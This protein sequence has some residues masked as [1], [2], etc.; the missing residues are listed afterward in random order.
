MK[1]YMQPQT[2]SLF[3][4]PDLMKVVGDGGGSGGSNIPSQPNTAPA[5]NLNTLYI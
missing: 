1:K 3:V 2:I 4:Y 5:R